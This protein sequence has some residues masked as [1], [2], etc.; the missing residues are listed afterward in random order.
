MFIIARTVSTRGY[1]LP[2]CNFL[3]GLSRIVKKKT[4]ALNPGDFLDFGEVSA[5]KPNEKELKTL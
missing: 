4:A 3:K 1:P 5:S 2:A